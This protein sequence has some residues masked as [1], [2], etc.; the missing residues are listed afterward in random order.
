M[1]KA[2]QQ[3]KPFFVWWKS[4]WMHIWTQLKAE[5]VGL[6]KRDGHDLTDYLSGQS[7]TSPRNTFHLFTDDGDYSAMRWAITTGRPITESCP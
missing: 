3:D 7:P 5:S 1:D 2:V 6:S 4:T